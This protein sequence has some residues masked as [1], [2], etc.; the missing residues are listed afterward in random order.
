MTD[1][2][3]ARFV[4]NSGNFWCN[5]GLSVLDAIILALI[6]TVVFAPTMAAWL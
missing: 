4:S 5:H 3:K 1:G 2:Q 6:P